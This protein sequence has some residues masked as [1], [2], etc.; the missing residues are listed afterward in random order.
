MTGLGPSRQA[1]VDVSQ[2]AVNLSLRR[3][4]ASAPS[5]Q[6]PTNVKLFDDHFVGNVNWNSEVVPVV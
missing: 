4:E 2:F 6:E 3:P 5:F 1:V